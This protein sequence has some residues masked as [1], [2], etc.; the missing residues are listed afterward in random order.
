M[1]HRG[2]RYT[3]GATHM[4]ICPCS[5]PD[6]SND[7]EVTTMMMES[8]STAFELWLREYGSHL[9]QLARAD[10]VSGPEQDLSRGVPASARN[11]NDPAH[12]EQ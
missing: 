10:N 8:K 4:F 9:E 1:N 5:P 6:Y 3:D 12:H 7:Q 2:L 11:L